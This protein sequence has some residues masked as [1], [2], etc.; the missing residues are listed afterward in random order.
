MITDHLGR[1]CNF[2]LTDPGSQALE[3]LRHSVG[4][5]LADY[6]QHLPISVD[7]VCALDIR[8]IWHWLQPRSKS[9]MWPTMLVLP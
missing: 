2:K 5:A 3:H 9:P 7:P 6:S 8:N 1:G 4:A